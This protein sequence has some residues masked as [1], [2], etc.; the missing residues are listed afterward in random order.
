MR[1]KIETSVFL[2]HIFLRA[3]FQVVHLRYIGKD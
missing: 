3:V 1:R 2:K